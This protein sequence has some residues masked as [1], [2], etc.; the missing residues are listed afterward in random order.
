MWVESEG[1][2]KGSQFYFTLPVQPVLPE[3]GKHGILL[4]H[5]KRFVSFSK[6]HDKTFALCFLYMRGENLQQKIHEIDEVMERNKR[7]YDFSMFEEEGIIALLLQDIDQ[8][9]ARMIC[10]RIVTDIKSK[11][12]TFETSFSLVS[13]PSDGDNPEELVEKVKAATRYQTSFHSEQVKGE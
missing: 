11:F 12:E 7:A 2:G 5:L 8:D 3:I 9:T 4:D 10:E 13:Y 6:R 1:E